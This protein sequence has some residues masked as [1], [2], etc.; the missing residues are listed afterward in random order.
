MAASDTIGVGFIGAGDISIL[1]ARAVAKCPGAKLVG[2]WNR[3]Q[4]RAKQRAAEFGCKNYESPETLV[5]DP[6]VQAV[7]I[8]TNLETHLEYTKLALNAGKHV[9]VEKPVGVSVAEIEEMKRLADAK[10]L[11]CMPGHNYIY[12]AG[13]NRSKELI[14][15]GDL[16]RIV[17]CY[18]MYNIHH[19]EEVAR[20]Y[21]GVVRQILTHN[22]YILLYL[23]GRPK[24]LCA[25]KACL[26]YKEY[27]EEDIAM[28]QIEL[29]NGAL[30]HLCAS[31]AADDHAADPWTVMVK[32]IGTAGSTRYSYRDHVEIKPGLVHSQ[33]YTAYAGSIVNEVRHFLDNCVRRGEAP[34]S[35][36]A[37]AIT[38]QK[39]I[40]ACE[41]SIREGAVVTL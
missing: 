26:H 18:A 9:L 20:R 23:A 28:V 40:E 6:A 13:M 7:F 36:M 3:G 12:E 14:E 11:V 5:R 30:A 33:T 2:L 37:D 25:M 21:P 41:K 39:M 34:L 35:T 16:G 10:K 17:S 29:E 4:D 22:S 24:R 27:K 32:V 1:H 8:L 15:A 19:P 38:A 31:F